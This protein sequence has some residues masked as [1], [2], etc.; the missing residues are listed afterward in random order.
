M[1]QP[2]NLGSPADFVG[3]VGTTE[4]APCYKACRASFPSLSKSCLVPNQCRE[5]FPEFD[6]SRG[7]S[8]A[9]AQVVGM[10]R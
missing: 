10:C 8:Q 2:K 9:V 3:F 1:Q 5:S 6:R 7:L 4:V